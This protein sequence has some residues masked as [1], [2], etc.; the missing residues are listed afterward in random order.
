MIVVVMVVVMNDG[1][2]TLGVGR[3]K[4]GRRREL[5]T[6]PRG[7]KLW[8]EYSYS[9]STQRPLAH[10][11]WSNRA[12]GKRMPFP[13]F[14]PFC[15]FVCVRVLTLHMNI[16]YC[17]IMGRMNYSRVLQLHHYLPLPSSPSVS[18]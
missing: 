7:K 10:A 18:T 4:T 2:S 13:A 8:V 1:W 17:I 6:G 5:L 12:G 11:D 9:I 15:V 3:R 16:Y 14:Y